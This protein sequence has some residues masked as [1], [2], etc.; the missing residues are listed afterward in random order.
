MGKKFMKPKN[1]RYCGEPCRLEH[2]DFLVNN[3]K[4]VNLI[5]VPLRCLASKFQILIMCN[6]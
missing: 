2:L 3:L 4:L 1:F 6:D 5:P